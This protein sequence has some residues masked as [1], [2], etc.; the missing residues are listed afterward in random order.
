MCWMYLKSHNNQIHC[1]NYQLHKIN[2][3]HL[4]ILDLF[5]CLIHKHPLNSP[6]Q[7]QV[8]KQILMMNNWVDMG[9]HHWYCNILYFLNLMHLIC[10]NTQKHCNNSHLHST[11]QYHHRGSY[12]CLY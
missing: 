1:N 5:P 3:Y 2:I 9:N 12:L 8:D 4:N 10:H 11:R 6:I 7:Q